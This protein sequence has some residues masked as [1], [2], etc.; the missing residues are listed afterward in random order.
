VGWEAP[1]PHR[2]PSFVYFVHTTTHVL[3]FIERNGAC[4][5]GDSLFFHPLF[6]HAISGG[7]Q[8]ICPPPITTH[9]SPPHPT[10]IA[11]LPELQS[12]AL[13]L[14]CGCR[15]P[16]VAEVVRQVEHVT[17][18]ELMSPVSANGSEEG[19][20]FSPSPDRETSSFGER[21]TPSGVSLASLGRESGAGSP[22]M[23]RSPRSGTP[24][25]SLF[26]NNTPSRQPSRGASWGLGGKS[27]SRPGSR[28]SSPTTIKKKV[29]VCLWDM[30]HHHRHHHRHHKELCQLSLL[31]VLRSC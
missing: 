5:C 27:G 22:A 31:A 18:S 9:T 10:P 4:A 6:F 12:F 15:Y 25:P 26:G 20:E 14:I 13:L 7:A 1:Q 19:D 29:R 8:V 3:S 23:G 2:T 16:A 24:P 28:S 11:P 17:D 30:N 21:R